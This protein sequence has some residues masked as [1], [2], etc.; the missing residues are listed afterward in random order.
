MAMALHNP[1]KVKMKNRGVLDMDKE[2]MRDFA[3]TSRKG[4]PKKKKRL[5][6][7]R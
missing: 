7:H 1:S 4:L 6:D 3:S 2:D 5:L